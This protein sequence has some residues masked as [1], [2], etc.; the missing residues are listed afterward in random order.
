MGH[1]HRVAHLHIHVYVYLI[2][3]ISMMVIC[4]ASEVMRYGSSEDQGR[5]I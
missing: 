3:V 1:S 2:V 5:S 4:Y